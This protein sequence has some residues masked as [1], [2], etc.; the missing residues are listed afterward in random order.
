MFKPNSS[1]VK[2]YATITR[3]KLRT[4]DS[5][6]TT[7]NIYKEKHIEIN[8][9]KC[10]Q[11]WMKLFTYETGINEERLC[12]QIL[13]SQ[14]RYEQ[15]KNSDSRHCPSHPI[16]E[17]IDQNKMMTYMFYEKNKIEIKYDLISCKA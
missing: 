14:S 2:C 5:S 3:P 9:E 8:I 10:W 13:K 12:I 17:T 4:S 15:Y 6:K 11:T 7:I 16:D 1:E